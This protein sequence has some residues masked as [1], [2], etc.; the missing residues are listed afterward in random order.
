MIAN[1]PRRRP[2]TRIDLRYAVIRTDLKLPAR[3]QHDAFEDALGAAE[4][5]LLLEDM[6][7]RNVRFPRQRPQLH[8][9][10]SIA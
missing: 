8:G 1:T 5:Y 2:G 9:E 10:F 3:Q 4:M 6:R 7:K